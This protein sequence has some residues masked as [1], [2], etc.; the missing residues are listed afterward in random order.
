MQQYTGEVINVMVKRLRS[1]QIIPEQ[2]PMYV[3]DVDSG[4]QTV[5]C[6]NDAKGEASDDENVCRTDSETGAYTPRNA[7]N[8]ENYEPYPVFGG[9]H[10]IQPK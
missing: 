5:P 7:E 4:A 10:R 3:T 1:F 8:L 9:K 2:A 6:G